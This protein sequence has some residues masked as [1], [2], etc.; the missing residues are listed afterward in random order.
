MGTNK[1]AWFIY[2][3]LSFKEKHS[4]YAGVVM[5]VTAETKWVRFIHAVAAI[6]V[7]SFPFNLSISQHREYWNKSLHFSLLPNWQLYLSQGIDWIK[8]VRAQMFP[9]TDFFKTCHVEYWK[10]MIYF[11]QKDKKNNNNG[12]LPTSFWRKH[13]LKNTPNLKNRA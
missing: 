4:N 12:G 7:L 10:V 1:S 2:S 9:R 8:D 13:A 6:P 11:R 3:D 5:N